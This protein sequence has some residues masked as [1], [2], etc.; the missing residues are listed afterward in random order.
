MTFNDKLTVNVGIRH[1]RMTGFFNNDPDKIKDIDYDPAELSENEIDFEDWSWSVGANYLL[2]ERSAIYASY[3]RAFSLPS[4]GL[5]T[6]IPEKNEIVNN[7]EL[8]Y[9]VGLGDLG[10]DFGVFN[11]VI[12]N[13]LAAVFDPQATG[14]QTFITR[15]V[16]TNKVRGAELELTYAPSSVKGLLFPGTFTLQSV[17]FDGYRSL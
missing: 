4:V 9:R 10:I 16:G 11:T 15:P 8:G 1:D 17:E 12:D 6:P 14:G 2:K 7:I 5:A 13:R 3:L